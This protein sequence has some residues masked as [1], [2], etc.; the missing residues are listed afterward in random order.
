MANI[1]TIYELSQKYSSKEG[2]IKQFME[3]NFPPFEGFRYPEGTKLLASMTRLSAEQAVVFADFVFSPLIERQRPTS[4]EEAELALQGP[5]REQAVTLLHTLIYDLVH[6]KQV[7]QARPVAINR[8]AEA[9]R[10]NVDLKAWQ[11]NWL[12]LTKSDREEGTKH[13]AEFT[14][15]ITNAICEEL[16]INAPDVSHKYLPE[17][18]GRL[19]STYI[20]D[21][22]DLPSIIYVAI[23]ESFE[24]YLDTS[25]HEVTHYTSTYIGLKS[26]SEANYEETKLQRDVLSLGE[27]L[28]ILPEYKDRSTLEARTLSKALATDNPKEVLSR[29]VA[30]AVTSAILPKSF[31]EEHRPYMPDNR[32]LLSIKQQNRFFLDTKR[33]GLFSLKAVADKHGATEEEFRAIRDIYFGKTP[34]LER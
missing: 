26:A 18:G 23:N 20:D 12:N 19:G 16:K 28:R 7:V 5:V 14:Q 32:T 21:F 27:R 34:E 30:D 11:E 29:Q 6:H 31:G 24:K 22:G 4:N 8:M 9:I 15:E 33:R 13:C 2:D 3:D 10:E 25:V 1:V 17:D